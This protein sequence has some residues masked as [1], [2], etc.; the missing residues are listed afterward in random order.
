M[1]V[2]LVVAVLVAHCLL[3]SESALLDGSTEHELIIYKERVRSVS[4][5]LANECPSYIRNR[6]ELFDNHE[7]L[8]EIERDVFEKLTRKLIE[9]RIQNKA[10]STTTTGFT[11]TPVR[12]QTTSIITDKATYFSIE[13]TTTAPAVVALSTTTKQTTP[14]TTK[15]TTPI[16]TKQ[17][18]PTTTAPTQPVECQQAVN[19]TQSWRR[20]HKGSNIKPGGLH[21]D[22]GYACDLGA[23]S[24]QWFRSVVP[25]HL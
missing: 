16:T 17:T 20:D 5:R 8:L 10:K 13:Q 18:T 22:V 14:T 3:L 25:N 4:I 19:Y 11:T 1:R 12:S 21:S 15:Q 2:L 7:T 24:S 23:S 9:C 6:R